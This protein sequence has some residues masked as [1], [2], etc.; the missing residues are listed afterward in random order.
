MTDFVKDDGDAVEI[1]G[2]RYS[3]EL[4]RAWGE[5]G[6]E[7]GTLF[8]LLGR[9]NGVVSIQTLPDLEAIV[10][11]QAE[12]IEMLEK[13]REQ[14]AIYVFHNRLDPVADNLE[15]ALDAYGAKYEDGKKGE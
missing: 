13:V 6:V 2:I 15:E 9:E 3:K 14:A 10:A 7:I 1:E 12:R 4:F 11:Q 8:K 5:K